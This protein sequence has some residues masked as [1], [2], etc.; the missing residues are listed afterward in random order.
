MAAANLFDI[1]NLKGNAKT[2]RS[3]NKGVRAAKMASKI[4]RIMGSLVRTEVDH[5]R[6]VL[7]ICKSRDEALTISRTLTAMGIGAKEKPI[8]SVSGNE[9]WVFVAQLA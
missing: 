1:E 8:L 4:Q 6:N 9:H 7:A 3:L 5:A 2:T